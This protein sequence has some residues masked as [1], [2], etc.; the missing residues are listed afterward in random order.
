LIIRY[1]WLRGLEISC[2][3]LRARGSYAVADAA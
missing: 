1:F 3:G 2:G